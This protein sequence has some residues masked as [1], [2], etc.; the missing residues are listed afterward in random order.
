MHKCASVE[1]EG[2]LRYREYTPN[3]SDRS[4]RVAEIYGSSI[5]A[6][7]RSAGQNGSIS[8]DSEHAANRPSERVPG[9]RFFEAVPIFFRFHS[10]EV[11]RR[12]G[13]NDQDVLLRVER[14][15]HVHELI[16]EKNDSTRTQIVNTIAIIRERVFPF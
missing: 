12:H 9:H 11:Q 8:D 1:V 5:L 4:V 2:E 6:L 14:Q 13:R 15:S 10:K 3:E 7:D 16:R